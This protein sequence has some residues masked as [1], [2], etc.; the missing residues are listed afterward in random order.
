MS[1]LPVPHP[2]TGTSCVLP[3]L[4]GISMTTKT[5]KP[6]GPGRLSVKV[7]GFAGDWDIT[8]KDAAG[9]ELAAGAGTTTGGGAPTTAGTDTLEF[10][11]KKAQPLQISICNYLGSP[12]AK[13]SYT[14][15]YS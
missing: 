5:I 14:F 2:P 12:Q 7:T 10:K 13:A 15:T 11:L 3:Q 4:E 1:G 9:T 6:T 8:L